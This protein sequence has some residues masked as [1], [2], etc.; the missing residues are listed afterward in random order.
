MPVLAFQLPVGRTGL[1]R[2]RM[3]SFGFDT[4]RHDELGLCPEDRAE[5]EPEVHGHPDD[6]RNIGL[7]QGF[8]ANPG[9]CQRM[10]G[11]NRTAG[12]PVHQHGDLEFLG[13]A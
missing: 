3:A 2:P 1:R 8:S 5:P 11:G 9:E 10:V 13:K 7:P 4:V 12:H 6:Q